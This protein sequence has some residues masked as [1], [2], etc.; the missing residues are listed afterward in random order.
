M[1]G[2]EGGDAGGDAGADSKLCDSIDRSDWIGRSVTANGR[3]E[4]MQ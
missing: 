1:G 4:R 3:R 2:D